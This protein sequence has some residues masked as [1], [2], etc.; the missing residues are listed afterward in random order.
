[1]EIIALLILS[2]WLLVLGFAVVLCVSARRTDEELGTELAPVVDLQ[3]RRFT[4]RQH[5]A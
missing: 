3:S 5:V 1:M 2:A 4:S